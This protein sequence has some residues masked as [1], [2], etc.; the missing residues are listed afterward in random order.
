[1]EY[2]QQAW[3]A[4]IASALTAYILAGWIKKPR[5]PMWESAT[6]EGPV[7]AEGYNSLM[8]DGR[9]E[10]SGDPRAG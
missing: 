5:C 8:G 3:L 9:P 6:G 1:M 2:S 10:N 7:Y 4:F